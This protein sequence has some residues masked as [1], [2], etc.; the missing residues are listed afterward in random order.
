MEKRSARIYATIGAVMGWFTVIIQL[1]LHILNRPVAF[2]ESLLRFFG[3]FTI[4]TNIL[5][6]LFLTFVT[7]QSKSRLGRFFRKATTATA[8]T[9]YI[10]IVGVTYN[11]LLRNTWNPQGM[12]KLV[13]EL[14]HSV[15]PVYFV[16]FWFIFV[17]GKDLKWKD[18]FPWLIYPISYM[19]YA[20]IL[21]AITMFYPYPFV[22]VNE[23]GYTKALTNSL[24]VLA[25]IFL[26]S[27]AFIGI[28]KTR[29]K[30]DSPE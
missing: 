1:Y 19:V 18:A 12:Q 8:L 28:G 24:I 6:A 5:C 29:K 3:Y 4:D 30:F 7:L 9:A 21:G 22:D 23:L 16:L 27:L 26:L 20:I 2:G 10:T 13:D 14:L 25:L 15:I 17:P 11:I